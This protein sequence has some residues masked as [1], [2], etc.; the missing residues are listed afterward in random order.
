MP[1]NLFRQTTIAVIWDFDKTLIPGYMETPI[2]RHFDVDEDR[3]WREVD[4][5]PEFYRK[6]GLDMISRDS[7]YLTHML[8]YVRHGLFKG[9]S[10]AL[11]REL[12]AA[13][14]FHPGLPHFFDVLK[15]GIAQHPDYAGA[16]IGVEHYIVSS[17]LRQMILGSAIAPHVDGVW[18]C[19]FVEDIAPPGYLDLEQRRLFAAEP[20]P[21]EIVAVGYVLDNTTKT[22]AIFEINKGTNKEPQIDVNAQ[23]KEEDRRIPLRNMIYVADGPSDIPVFS[24][25]KQ[26]GG[27]PY[28]VYEP[29][30]A[31]EF[32]QVRELQAQGRIFAF[33]PADYREGSHTFMLI[34]NGV[35][36]VAR[37][38]I[39]DRQRMVGEKIGTPPRH[40]G[41]VDPSEAVPAP[42]Q[43]PLDDA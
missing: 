40:I 29:G 20:T 16:E 4:G 39:A 35:E 15:N 6:R 38:I 3:F 7:L 19:E 42:E 25:I 23:I 11:L 14:A 30:G 2:F 28:A 9:L 22:R 37:R 1:H 8:T 36:Q 18:G 17:G 27:Q 13:L 12:G 10:N 33:G 24:I 34:R 43:L 32:R 26:N 5:L 31:E 41:D 21:R